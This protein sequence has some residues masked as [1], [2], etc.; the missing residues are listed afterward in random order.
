MESQ[1][2]MDLFNA[3]ESESPDFGN[4]MEHNQLNVSHDDD[5]NIDSTTTADIDNNDPIN[6]QDKEEQTEH[7]GNIP[8]EKTNHIQ[9]ESLWQ[10]DSV[11]GTEPVTH[12]DNDMSTIDN[13]FV[14]ATEEKSKEESEPID[15]NQSVD[16]TEST[17]NETISN[18][19]ING[20]VATKTVPT[21]ITFNEIVPTENTTSGHQDTIETNS[22]K[23]DI[24]MQEEEQG[25]EHDK[26]QD[27]EQ[28]KEESND[29]DNLDMSE[30]DN[31][32]SNHGEKESSSEVPTL[33]TNNNNDNNIS[34]SHLDNQNHTNNIEDQ[35]ENDD[36]NDN[37]N[38]G[39]EDKDEDD[40]K[41]VDMEGQESDA[42][43]ET[44][45]STDY[46]KSHNNGI[47]GGVTVTTLNQGPENGEDDEF[48]TNDNNTNN[49]NNNSLINDTGNEDDQQNDNLGLND[50]EEE[51]EEEEADDEDN[52]E[53]THREKST[54]FE[55]SPSVAISE[56]EA[57]SPA[58]LNTETTSPQYFVENRVERTMSTP[59]GP[60]PISQPSNN[61]TQRAQS[62]PHNENEQ[63]QPKGTNDETI[64]QKPFNSTQSMHQNMDRTS[65]EQNNQQKT[66]NQ[67][68][69]KPHTR[70]VEDGIIIPQTHEIVIPSYSTWFS[71]RKIHQIEKKSLPE[72]FTNRIAS[73]T[74]EIY[75]KY[76]NFMVNSYRLNPNEYFS[77]TAARRNLSGDAA[78]IFRIHKFI[79]KWGLIN[80]QVNAK[81]LPKTVEPPYTNDFST[82]HD[83]PRGIFPFESYKPS[84]QL[85]DM[86]KLKKMMDIEDERST[87]HKYLSQ[88]RK[89][90]FAELEQ[91]G[92]NETDSSHTNATKESKSEIVST[93][94][95][96]AKRPNI[97]NTIN[98][99]SDKIKWNREDLKKLLFGIQTYGSDWYKV[100]KHVGTKTP[101]QCVLRFLQLPI[102]DK[103]LYQDISNLH[104]NN[105]DEDKNTI[106]NINDLGPLKYAPHLPFSKSESPVLST[107]AFLVGLVDPQIVQK[108][109]NRAIRAMDVDIE[110]IPEE[111]EKAK[112]KEDNSTEN[113][114]KPTVTEDNDKV[115][116]EPSSKDEPASKITEESFVPEIE[117]PT[118]KDNATAD[119]ESEKRPETAEVAA[120]ETAEEKPVEDETTKASPEKSENIDTDIV[121][122]GTADD[123]LG[124][125]EISN[126]NTD[127]LF[128]DD[129]SDED[130]LAD[131][132]KNEEIP[133]V[134]NADAKVE[135]TD[136]YKEKEK[137]KETENKMESEVPLSENP[138]TVTNAIQDT[139][140]VSTSPQ[141]NEKDATE[142]K[143]EDVLETLVEMRSSAKP[144]E[145]K[146]EEVTESNDVPS[147]E[148]KTNEETKEIEVTKEVVEVKPAEKVSKKTEEH[149][150]V[151]E[152]S[153]IALASL[154]VRSHVFANNEER[155]MNKL[156]N[157][158]IQIQLEKLET[159]LKIFD[160]LERSL[161]FDRKKLERKQEEF[162][163]QRLSFAKTSNLLVHKF[164]KTLDTLN[165]I[166]SGNSNE[167]KI[168]DSL[169]KPIESSVK[170]MKDLLSRPLYL[171]FG[172]KLEAAKSTEGTNNEE[173]TDLENA[174]KPISIE[175]PQVYRYWSA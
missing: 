65:S 143:P 126:D 166:K 155:Q 140:T 167:T 51:E 172:S 163:V 25:E 97:L 87:L 169:L 145:E 94:E 173:K 49:S 168:D 42:D 63:N 110:E 174:M 101:E 113:G 7:T 108:M 57:T 129:N 35:N 27:K 125:R 146:K 36:D 77:V 96:P 84:V 61:T 58:T 54:D 130:M 131:E 68:I 123:Q 13:S 69:S 121:M 11:P 34:S 39:D 66:D 162:L 28:D 44:P 100:A 111:Q 153:E 23:N 79:M 147:V 55:A 85:P 112:H 119:P 164:D 124:S 20:N 37:D 15:I 92:M 171:S 115:K 98:Q 38:N 95:R 47:T 76:R 6:E 19:N 17:P 22:E 81:Q 133:E 156:A 45:M 170:E 105:K 136:E 33:D 73:K 56:S 16:N 165:E 60:L 14:T 93:D 30:I 104:G 52:D 3:S 4:S 127:A 41:D 139:T 40:E 31:D 122:G 117:K 8:E 78:S 75:I 82:K 1:S 106:V 46:K 67:S 161:E 5:N 150:D 72:F 50:E 83:A 114:S 132:E 80:Y 118:V 21:G 59:T 74:P 29:L 89:R 152:G 86:A 116:E 148:E 26:E 138:A 141:S 2:P 12:N 88:E 64:E 149:N 157:Q 154:G 43:T 120:P 90:N 142:E 71:L 48:S 103:F 10:H 53:L 134:P 107:I 175:N 32:E 102:E 18:E 91:N 24:D 62:Q 128:G 70:Q 99:E 137:E 144:E 158:M 151:K 159:K 109:T 135:Q 9:D 160:K